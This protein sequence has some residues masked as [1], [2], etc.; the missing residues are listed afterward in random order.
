MQPMM[1]VAAP[2]KPPRGG[3]TSLL[4][5]ILALVV[6]GLA[7]GGSFA[8]ISTFRQV[9]GGSESVFAGKRTWWSFTDAGSSDPIVEVT[10]LAGLVIVLAA[11]LLVLGA[12]YAF[13]AA[14]AR[15]PGIVTASRSL[16]VAGASVLTGAALLV[17]FDVLDQMD[18]FNSR[19]LREGDSIDFNA[20]IGLYLP[21]GAV[22]LGIVAVVFAHVGQ[23]PQAMRVEPNTPRMGFQ[24]P[25]GQR[26]YGQPGS[27]P[28]APSERPTEVEP[29]RQQTTGP[30]VS[31]DSS[32]DDP[33]GSADT[34]VVSN[35]T[36]TQ[37][38]AATADATSDATATSDTP[39]AS[40][41]SVAP[42]MAGEPATTPPAPV[43]PAGP[44]M[45]T[46]PPA[47]PPAGEPD[48]AP[49]KADPTPLTDLPPAP[50]A[51]ELD[52]KKND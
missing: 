28:V 16:I 41:T 30:A 15:T 9:F 23:R 43:A 29:P 17:L 8:P 49:E 47:E 46:L 26:P 3:M 11:A 13:M 45:T 50:P 35:A 38:P 31:T 52:E 32:V 22:V 36:A 14:R 6:A 25:Y 27:A 4:A 24:A 42:A 37:T 33:D 51:P 1:G 34:Q 39:A 7:I 20:G 5:G 40:S 10:Y 48:A 21:L 19:D 2:P 44:A 18:D 12:V